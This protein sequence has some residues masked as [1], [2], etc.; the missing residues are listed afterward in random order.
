MPL[1]N[2]RWTALLVPVSAIVVACAAPVPTDVARPSFDGGWSAGDV[3][4]DVILRDQFGDDVHLWQFAGDVVLLDI[5]AMWCAPCREAVDVGEAIADDCDGQDFSFVTVLVEDASG[6]RVAATDAAEWAD[7]LGATGPV[8]ADEDR[9]T[10]AAV[11]GSFPTFLVLDRDLTVT[12]VTPDPSLANLST[13][14]AS[15]L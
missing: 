7:T 12:A 4:P 8:L 6:G 2:H 14:V 3:V 15:E 13:L 9:E 1:A 5:S 10:A 11:H